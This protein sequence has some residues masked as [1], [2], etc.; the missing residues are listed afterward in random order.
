MLHFK[1]AEFKVLFR[2]LVSNIF[3]EKYKQMCLL[4]SVRKLDLLVE[5]Y[6]VR[7]K[8]RKVLSIFG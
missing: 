8:E 5:K 1:F 7:A 2:V 6:L 3:T 4:H